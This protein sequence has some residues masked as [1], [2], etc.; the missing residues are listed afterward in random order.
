MFSKIQMLR[1]ANTWILLA[2]GALFYSCGNN[3]L[4]VDVSKTEVKQVVIK[5]FDRDFF[6]LNADNIVQKLPD[7]QKKYPGF[8]E[9]FVKNIL[10]PAGIQ[11]NACIPEITRF[12]NDKDMKAAYSECQKQFQSL[13]DIG[14][15]LTDVYRH[16]NYY[17]PDKKLPDVA[18]MMSGFNYSIATADSVFGIGLEMYLGKKAPFYEM[19]Q[20]PNY[21]RTTMQKEYIACDFLHAML[22]IDFPNNI[23]NKTLLGEMI[24][25]GR[26][27]YLTDA[28]MPD[29]EDTIKIGFTKKQLDWCLEHEKDMWGHLIQNKFLYSP[30]VEVIS[31]FT[32]EGPF[33]TGF[34]KESPARTGVWIGWRIVKKYM[35]ENPK[36][37]LQQLMSEVDP[38]KILSLSKYK[39]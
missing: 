37:N 31:K 20:I 6:S 18:A 29:A 21:K 14:L 27:L 4:S 30:E 24:F 26:L 19:M 16:Y 11:D 17:F 28:M 38:Q 32:G 34:V 10:C 35:E 22:M 9:L 7:L 25:Q 8:A 12:I 15:Q 2:A 36:I 1:S 5:R 3:P 13:D 23:Q 33:T 39:P